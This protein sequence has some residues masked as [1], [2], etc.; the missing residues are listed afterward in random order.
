MDNRKKY[1]YRKVHI[2]HVPLHVHFDSIFIFKNSEK[3]K[4][5]NKKEKEET[6]MV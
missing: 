5:N 2:Q 1:L 6:K 4:Q 3:Y